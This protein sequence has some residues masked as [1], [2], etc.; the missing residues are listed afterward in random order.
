MNTNIPLLSEPKILERIFDHIDNKTT[1]LGDTVWKEP[2]ANSID[3]RSLS[4]SG[5]GNMTT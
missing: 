4:L 3:G 5:P 2:V 1:D